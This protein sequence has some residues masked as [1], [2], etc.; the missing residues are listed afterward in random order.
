MD[1]KG[2]FH[3]SAAAGAEADHSPLT[4]ADVKE[5]WIYTTAPPYASMAWFLV[6]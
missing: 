5:T 4:S 1:T 6:S 3:V 2:S